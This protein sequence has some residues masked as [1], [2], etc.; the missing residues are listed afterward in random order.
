MKLAGA[1]GLSNV[2]QRSGSVSFLT[3]TEGSQRLVERMG[4]LDFHC[5]FIGSR[6][7]TLRGIDPDDS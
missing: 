4:D 2:R 1:N 5:A 7:R 3:P 6:I